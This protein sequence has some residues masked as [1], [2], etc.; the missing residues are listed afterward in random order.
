M[1]EFTLTIPKESDGCEVKYLLKNHFHLSAAMI[2]RLKK[3]DGIILNGRV[4]FV[5][6]IV[7]EGDVLTVQLADNASE[8][9]VPNDIPIDILYEDEDVLA[10]NK[11]RNMP[12]HPSFR[13][14]EGTL[15][16]AVSYYYRHFPFTFRAI[17][18][19]DRDTSGIVLIAKN[20]VSAA[21]L[22]AQLQ[23]GQ[24]HK[25][26]EALCTGIPSPAS[27]KIEAPIRREREGIIKRCV[28]PDGKYALSEYQ[29]ISEH[30]GLSLIRLTPITGRT[31]QLRVHLAHIGIPIYGDYL[32][33]TEIQGEA[34]R[35]HCRR[36]NFFQPITGTPIEITA[37]LPEDMK[38]PTALV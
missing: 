28:A 24:L 8:N 27:G 30:D 3:T 22:S 18:R 11:P 21:A 5:T 20:A 29:L 16:N 10:V 34:P 7:S 4:V 15:A 36:I 23:T 17:T 32:Y 6:E 38:N 13:H 25:E 31:H 2:T 33:G 1:R 12:T 19:L 9:I 37:P 26:Y 14:Y 35:L